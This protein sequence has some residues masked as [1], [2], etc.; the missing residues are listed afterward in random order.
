MSKKKD[1]PKYESGD[2]YIDKADGNEAFI[3]LETPIGWACVTLETSE[4]YG[5]VQPTAA[6][7]VEGLTKTRFRIE[8]AAR[9]TPTARS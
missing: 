4:T 2:L 3:L 8:L 1:T 6:A 9:R 7:A 5:G